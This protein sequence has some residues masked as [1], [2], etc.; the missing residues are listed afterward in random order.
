MLMRPRSFWKSL[1][2]PGNDWPLALCDRRSLNHQE[3]MITA[4]VVYHNRFT[5]NEFVYYNPKHKWYY[6]KDLKDDEIIMFVQQDSDIELGG[7]KSRFACRCSQC[8]E[9]C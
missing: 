4:D 1:Q 5:E 8:P 7:G 2:G 3:D 6:V 9:N